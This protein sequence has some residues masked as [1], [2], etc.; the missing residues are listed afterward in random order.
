M[1]SLHY[2]GSDLKVSYIYHDCFVVETENTILV[3][4]YWKD[5][6]RSPL[7]FQANGRKVYVFVSHHHK[8]HFNKDIFRWGDHF[9]D[10]HFIISKDTFRS[11]RYMLVD[12]GTYRGPR[13]PSDSVTVLSEGERY[14]DSFIEAEA[15]GSTD[16]GN[17]YLVDVD[18]VKVFHAGDLNAWIWKDESTEAEVAEALEAF[19]A[20]LR[21]LRERTQ[22]ID[23]AM[24]PED[25]RLGTD[26]AMG[27]VEFR[28]MFDI[29]S[30]FP[31]HQCL[32]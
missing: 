6:K 10:I 17:S 7:D 4:D 16:I 11:V 26:Y 19:K 1:N 12:G 15:F 2:K 13:P 3:F 24:F 9:P 21:P 20:K 31:M 23:I 30:Y 5:G 27:A 18:G 22:S 32:V 29:G 8:D 28:R 25:P 14:S